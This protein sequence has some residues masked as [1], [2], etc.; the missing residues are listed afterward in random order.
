MCHAAGYEGLNSPALGK[1]FPVPWVMSD[2]HNV[3]QKYY[4]LLGQEA[5]T[6]DWKFVTCILESVS[7]SNVSAVQEHYSEGG[8]NNSFRKFVN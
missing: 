1:N 6:V 3:A 2:F 5:V 7:A 4:S 8:S